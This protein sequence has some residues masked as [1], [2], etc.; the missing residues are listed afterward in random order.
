MKKLIVI[1]GPTASGKTGLSIRLAKQLETEIVSADSM[2]IYRYMDIGSAKPS[3]QEMDGV[4][5]HLI[6]VI[7]PFEDF[8]VKQYTDLAKKAVA[9]IQ[10]KG[11]IPILAGGTGLFIN[12][13][14][15][16]IIFT[17][18][19][20]DENIRRELNEF[21]EKNGNQALHQILEKIDP[22]S[23][24]KIHFNDRKR[25]VRAIEI[26]RTTGTP[27]SEHIKR[28]RLIPSPYDLCYIGLTM[29]RKALYQRIDLRVDRMLKQGLLDEVKKLTDM[30]LDDSFQSMQGIGYK[31]MIWYLEKKISF[32]SAVET[33]KRESRRYAKRQ[34]TWFRRDDRIHWFDA[35]NEN[36]FGQ[37]MEMVGAFLNREE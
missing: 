26:Y 12:S 13:L 23:A 19:D 27:M 4:P 1:A 25:T 33:I 36:L 29:D 3:P 32:E 28:S 20:T 10:K 15:D 17:D 22:E 31:E 14:I 16:N 9:D 34:L 8:S 18:T 21:A 37:V 24:G 11:K 7:S 5:H 6:G 30:G 35:E 2:Q